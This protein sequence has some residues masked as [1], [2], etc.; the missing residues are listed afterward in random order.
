M[1]FQAWYIETLAK[2]QVIADKRRAEQEAFEACIREEIRKENL[3]LQ[4][5]SL[6][7]VLSQS[8]ILFSFNCVDRMDKK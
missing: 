4:L 2:G 3:A 1:D 8:S 5:D 6:L 7:C